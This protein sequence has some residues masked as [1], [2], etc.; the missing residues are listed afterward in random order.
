MIFVV[1]VAFSQNVYVNPVKKEM[2]IIPKHLKT[3]LKYLSVNTKSPKLIQQI[4]PANY[5]VTQ[6]GFFCKQEIKFEKSTKIPFKFRL[7]S[8]AAC[9]Q[10]EGKYRRN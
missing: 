6:L 9:D 3:D 1:S 8:V 2:L 7:G 5:Y 4:L 10:M